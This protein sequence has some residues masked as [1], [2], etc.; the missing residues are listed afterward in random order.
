MGIESLAFILPVAAVF[1]IAVFGGVA[2]T[3]DRKKK[4]HLVLSSSA[5]VAAALLIAYIMLTGTAQ[6]YVVSGLF[7]INAFSLF[8]SLIFTLG[9]FLVNIIAFRY[10]HDYN[11]F[12]LLSSFALIGMYAVAFSANLITLLIGLELST[13]PVV[14]MILLTRKS[15]EAAA[16]L[17]IIAS[18]SVALLSFSVVLTYGGSGSIMLHGYSGGAVLGFAALLFIVSLGFEASIFPFNVLLPD[19]YSGSP[20]HI[21]SML[22][23]INKKVGFAALMQIM[24]LGF[25][26]YKQAF[27]LTAVLAVLTMFYGNLVALMQDNIKRMMAYSSISQAG[28]ILIGIAVADSS[29]IEA[30]LVQIFAHMF[31]FIGVLTIV[32][33]LEEHGRHRID[34]IEGLHSENRFLSFSLAVFLLSL[35]GLPFTTGFVG[36]F[37]LFFSAVNSGL[38][39]LAFIGIINSIIS[40][41][42]Y[43]R[44]ITKVYSGRRV[45]R[46]MKTGKEVGAVVIAC[47]VIT[48]L[49]G[50]YPA[51]LIHV[52]ANA[53][54]I[55]FGLAPK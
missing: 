15:L 24:I 6:S 1:A 21:T 13:L 40:I 20:A 27:L 29:G 38:A 31:I 47:V 14:F 17:F 35:A 23:G 16:K 18:L 28:Y 36:K 10:S 43:A 45:S 52:A 8:F 44:V 55:L 26:V 42:Y 3:I 4:A 5:Y 46:G 19:V 54:N 37:L 32:A 30:S 25:I 11:E 39:W 50:I 2:L 9:I 41:Y 34:D 12:A 48:L 33:W 53:A 51:P 7:S 49:F 22:G